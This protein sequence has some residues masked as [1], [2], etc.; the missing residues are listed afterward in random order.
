[1]QISRQSI[2]ETKTKLTITLD[3]SELDTVKAHVLKDLS[4]QVK[5]PG[6]RP[7]KAPQ[8]VVEKNVD[9]AVFQN[10][11]LEHAINDYYVAAAQQESLKP[12]AQP[13][14]EIAKFVPFTT[15]EFNAT[16]EAVGEIKLGSYKNLKVSVDKQPVT[17][18]DVKQIL[19]DLA[20]RGATREEVSRAAKLGDEVTI[21]FAG[22]DAKTDESIPGTDG[23]DYPLTLGS[24]TFI[25]GFEDGVVGHKAGDAFDL[26]I[27]F[28]KDYGAKNLQN[29]RVIF[30]IT[31]HK[32]S[33]VKKAKIDDAFAATVGPFKTLAELKTDIKK[34][35]DAERERDYTRQLD[36]AL[37]EAVTEKSTIVLPA[38]LIED[39]MDRMEDEEK[40]NVVY[41]GQTWQEHLDAEMLTAEAHREKQRE[42]ATIRVKAGLV[43][44]EIAA[45]EDIQVTPEELEIRMQLLKGQ[46]QDPTMLAELDKPENRR[47]VLN[48]MI[49]EKTL[50]RL[51]SLNAK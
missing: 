21:D 34:Q 7:G 30:N 10:E 31:V 45:Q 51:R 9:Q 25:P 48:R 4:K 36:N 11:F 24:K 49:S 3:Q 13:E 28:P 50:D 6:F 22:R 43:L 32:V 38:A 8:A 37:L 16:V 2:T 35:L 41:R 12:V 14:I 18:D 40:R 5:V 15:L 27:T 29:K 17:A 23:Q 47:D 19:D 20:T 39:E 1:M 33:E 44:S 42:G 26:P 46:Y